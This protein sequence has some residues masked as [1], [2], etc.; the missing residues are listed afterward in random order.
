MSEQQRTMPQWMREAL[1]ARPDDQAMIPWEV[2][3]EVAQTD[4]YQRWSEMAPEMMDEPVI[5]AQY[6]ADQ[7]GAPVEQVREEWGLGDRISMSEYIDTVTKLRMDSVI[8]KEIADFV[9]QTEGGDLSDEQVSGMQK[10]LVERLNAQ[11][12]EQVNGAKAALITG[13]GTNRQFDVAKQALGAVFQHTPRGEY[14]KYAGRSPEEQAEAEKKYGANADFNITPEGQQNFRAQRVQEFFSAVNPEYSPASGWSQT[15]R[16]IGGPLASFGAAVDAVYGGKQSSDGN[17][18]Q[19]YRRMNE[20]GGKFDYAADAAERSQFDG[21]GE[22]NLFTEDGQPKFPSMSLYTPEGIANA[23]YFNSSYPMG[24]AANYLKG[25]A[26]W[27][28]YIGT[29]MEQGLGFAQDRASAIRELRTQGMR[30]TPHTIPGVSNE[31]MQKSVKEIER[32]DAGSDAFASAYLGPTVGTAIR[33]YPGYLS[34]FES[35]V[36]NVLGD[37]VTDPGNIAYNFV[38]P[39]LGA[40]NAAAKVATSAGKTMVPRLSSMLKEGAKAYGRGTVRAVGNVFPDAVEESAEN[41]ALGAVADP[42]GFF[43]PQKYNALV[44]EYGNGKKPGEEGYDPLVA[45]VNRVAAGTEAAMPVIEAMKRT[46]AKPTAMEYQRPPT[47]GRMQ[48]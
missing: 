29:A 46:R 5:S 10:M 4:G 44:E 45:N 27:G 41:F 39:G 34:G 19:D 2:S 22:Y 47:G 1:T 12:Q 48:Y 7:L 17:W 9:R 3:D 23:T 35:G 11:V 8:T 16:M 42:A 20:P 30:T 33:G 43:G 40:V 15:W 13:K 21:S 6:L 36:A 38:A 32:N 31:D 37:L 24:Y 28:D 26:Q 18:L 14:A 25:N